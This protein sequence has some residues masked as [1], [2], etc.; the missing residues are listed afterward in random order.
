LQQEL[1][2]KV[3]EAEKYKARLPKVTDKLR[4]AEV[5]LQV[6]VAWIVY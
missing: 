4:E 6:V 3:E 5:S 2:E 1:R